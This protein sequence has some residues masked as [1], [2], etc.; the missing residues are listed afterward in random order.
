MPGILGI[1]SPKREVEARTTLHEM[2]KGTIRGE[3]SV[4]GMLSFDE[5]GLNIGWVSQD[6][7]FAN[8]APVWNEEKTACLL[9]CGEHFTDGTEDHDGRG[10][11]E[12]ETDGKVQ[13]LVR[14]YGRNQDSFFESLNGV[15]SGVVVQRSAAE[16]VLFN[17]RYGL[18]RIYCYEANSRFYF[19]SEA[20]SLL[21]VLPETRNLDEQGLAEWFS[22]GSVLQNRTLFSNVYL[23]PPG[24]AWTFTAEGRLEKRQYFRPD[25]W[26]AQ[27]VLS[28]T[29]YYDQLEEL[30][31]RV[32]KRYFP[33]NHAVGMSL[34]GG[35]DGRMIMA[36]APKASR[37]L[38]CY[39]FSGPYRESADVR[40]A[41]EV[42][43]ACN[44]TH[45]TLSVNRQFFCE[46]PVLAEKAVYLS[47]G[48]MDV[49]GAA[50]LYVNRLAR[51]INPI[52]MTGNYGSEILRRHI[53]FRPSPPPEGIFEP[54]VRSEIRRAVD[55]YKEERSGHPLSFV[56]FKQMPWHHYARF[57]LEQSEVLVRSPFLDIDLVRLAFRAPSGAG[58]N[59][60]NLLRLIA[61]GRRSLTN[62]PTNRGEVY[63]ANQFTNKARRAWEYFFTK[64]EY[65]CDY[66]MPRWL[67]RLDS[68]LTPFHL[69][70]LFLGRQKFYHFRI[71]Y[72]EQLSSYVKEIL[73]DPRARSRPYLRGQSLEPMVMAHVRGEANFT[74]LIHKLLSMELLQRLL[75]DRS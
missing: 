39:T 26:E 29:E 45:E 56:A 7:L 27:S 62:I 71:W 36:W 14:L 52:R 20:K 58:Q 74:I 23:L 30:F 21:T 46:F 70:R 63:G 32:L 2:V 43:K 69:D 35:L 38:P 60:Q 41:R 47:D 19:S 68:V 28:E 12:A 11:R 66:G 53:A 49:S 61:T 55:V 24:S 40:L 44:Q 48:T 31:P 64:A 16:V 22:C 65:F 54:S 51:E 17:D 3:S 6:G 42:A 4:T 13:Q 33:A 1:I 37:K 25:N 9:F 50:E 5:M 34:T 57:A 72:R 75:I 15:Y 73:L 67:A 10:L 8:C 59:E 18:N